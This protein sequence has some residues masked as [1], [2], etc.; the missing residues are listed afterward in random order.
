VKK[1]VIIFIIIISIL[2]LSYSEDMKIRSIEDILND[3]RKE[4][5]L[6]ETDKITP[7][8]VNLQ[9]LEELGDAVMEKIIGNHEHHE[10]MDQMMGGEGSTNLKEMHQRIGYNYLKGNINGYQ[11]MMKY[12]GMMSE[13]PAKTSNKFKGGF[14][15]MWNNGYGMMGGVGWFGFIIGIIILII[16]S[17]TVYFV[18]KL[19]LKNN[20][21][22]KNI[23]FPIDILKKRYA[24]GEISKKDYEL[25]KKDIES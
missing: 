8:K 11:D 3:I 1:A 22:I 14:P 24:K 10:Q 2:L 15:M 19:I 16:I 7:D 17:L 6:K 13:Y 9:L 12:I 25:I 18:I 21:T 23:E 5:G 4:Q 20:S